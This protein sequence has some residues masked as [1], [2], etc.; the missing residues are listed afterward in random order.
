MLSCIQRLVDR[1]LLGGPQVLRGRGD[2]A[3]QRTYRM[4]SQGGRARAQGGAAVCHYPFVPAQDPLLG[5]LLQAALGRT[6]GQRHDHGFSQRCHRGTG[7]AGPAAAAAGGGPEDGRSGAHV[8]W[9]SVLGR[10]RRLPEVEVRRGRRRYRLGGGGGAPDGPSVGGP[11]WLDRTAPGG[12][13]ELLLQAAVLL[14]LRGRQG[15]P[16]DPPAAQR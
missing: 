12:T 4:G 13:A 6:A 15:G 1:V 3:H 11:P 8:G 2:A 14:Y 7:A 10:T 16:A 5:S 9:N